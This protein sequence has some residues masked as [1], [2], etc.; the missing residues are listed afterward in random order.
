MITEKDMSLRLK[1]EKQSDEEQ[2]Y[3]ES[4]ILKISEKGKKI[5]INGLYIAGGLALAYLLFKYFIED[6]KP[7]KT[8]KPV[9]IDETSEEVKE[10]FLGGITKTF[11][12]EAALII[13]AMAK[14]KLV[15]YLNKDSES[16]EE[17]PSRASK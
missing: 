2:K 1:L 4:E 11:A 7:R 16:N 17:H 8:T 5:A 3:L 14:D 9:K 6:E 13:L 10:S 12:K 15:E